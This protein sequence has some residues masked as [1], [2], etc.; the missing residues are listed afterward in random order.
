MGI[1]DITILFVPQ[2]HEIYRGSTS[3]V[4]LGRMIK[5]NTM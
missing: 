2:R 5:E 1:L 4:A 3:Q